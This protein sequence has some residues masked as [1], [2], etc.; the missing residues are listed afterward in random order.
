MFYQHH[1]TLFHGDPTTNSLRQDAE[2]GQHRLDVPKL[3]TGD[4]C[5][6]ANSVSNAHQLNEH[7]EP[8]LSKLGSEQES[9]TP[10]Y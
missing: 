1:G 6:L 3:R 7:G 4:I 8:S 5:H 2:R 10:V 9:E